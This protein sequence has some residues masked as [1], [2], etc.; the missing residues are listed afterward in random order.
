MLVILCNYSYVYSMYNL[1]YSII[2]ESVDS[3]ILKTEWVQKMERGS[4][5]F[6]TLK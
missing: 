5:N 2:H 4:R 6:I 1:Y 3:E